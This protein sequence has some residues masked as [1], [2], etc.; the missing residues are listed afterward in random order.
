MKLQP[1]FLSTLT[2]TTPDTLN[3]KDH[4]SIFSGNASFNDFVSSAFENVSER[5]TNL[6]NVISTISESSQ[7]TGNPE[8]LLILQK[9]INEYTN[10][11]SL[12]S[13]ISRKGIG[14]IETLEK[15]Q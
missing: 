1:E 7:L 6:K 3:D 13:T 5:T 8:N 14:T 9:Y 10:Y 11:V 12:I 15:A 4:T 2:Q